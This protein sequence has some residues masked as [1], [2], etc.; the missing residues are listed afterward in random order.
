MRISELE[1][2]A[3]LIDI[4]T[5][6]RNLKKA[7]DYTRNHDFSLR[8]HIKTHK[9]PALARK[10]IELGAVGITVA[11]VG[12]AEV[13]AGAEPPAL[14]IAYPVIG[15]SKLERLIEVA[16]NTKVTVGLDSPF[17]ARGLSDAA[18]AAQVEIG[19]LAEVDVG[20]GRVGVA[21]GDD[22][23]QLGRQIANLPWLRLDGITLYPGHVKSAG[24][25][26][27][28]QIEQ[29]SALL[30]SVTTGWRRAGLPLSVVS[31]GSTPSLFQSHRIS[32]LTEIRPGTYIF[33]DKN[34]WSMGAC[35][36]EDC[37]AAILTTVVS[38]ARPGQIIVDGGSKTFSSDR[39]GSAAEATY[40][41]VVDAPEAVFAKMN[42]EHGF[43]ELRGAKTEFSVGDRVRIIP[44][45]I[46][47]A[48]NLHEQ[49]Y[50]IRGDE[51][52]E[53]WRVAARGKLQ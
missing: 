37:A 31:G 7:A 8:P 9:I 43:V 36:L 29:L 34:C 39:L 4:D 42:E 30:Q 23:V 47:V 35:E 51:V 32:G 25:E 33:N 44:N 41:Y 3:I 16:R 17:A 1:T 49:V 45:H 24:E 48:M 40:G 10:Q 53:T 22:L 52:V 26:A 12:E 13:M 28:R 19:V 11:K 27:E 46:C 14:F 20:M 2:P 6:D 38:T 5:M 50:G 15:R 21:P 18:R